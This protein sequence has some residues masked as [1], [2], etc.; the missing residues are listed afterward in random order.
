[1]TDAGRIDPGVLTARVA[2]ARGPASFVA[3]QR[4]VGHVVERTGDRQFVLAFGDRRVSAQSVLPL[5]V[6]QRLD[7]EVIRSGATVELRLVTQPV[8]PGP[9]HLD[10]QVALAAVLTALRAS[11]QARPGEPGAYASAADTLRQLA[12]TSLPPDESRALAQHLLPIPVGTD[13]KAVAAAVREFLASGGLL[14]ETRLRALLT[15]HPGLSD[16][17]LLA[18]LRFDLK[19]LL[20][21]LARRT[22]DRRGVFTPPPAEAGPGPGATVAGRLQSNQLALAAHWLADGSLVFEFPAA[23]PGGTVNVRVRLRPGERGQTG[24]GSDA[25]APAPRSLVVRIEGETT[26]TIEARAQWDADSVRTVF[27]VDRDATRE[28]LEADLSAFT[29]SMREVFPQASADVRVDARHLRQAAA[30][31]GP[32]DLPARA[33]VD[34]RA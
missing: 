26:G 14:F 17:E 30:A 15:G 29:A 12:E 24:R 28:L 16:S 27:T 22:E 23:L 31:D 4:L 5:A 10:Q 11:A 6:G 21:H 32:P 25:G 9:R 13:A 2:D 8:S 3:G 18:M 19:T 7:V 1:M 34:V 33:I 20:G